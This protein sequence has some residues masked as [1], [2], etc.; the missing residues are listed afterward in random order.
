PVDDPRFIE[1]LKGDVLASEAVARALLEKGPLNAYAK[2]EQRIASRIACISSNGFRV[3]IEKTKH[4]VEEMR[5]RREAILREFEDKYGL[6]T[7]GDA[8]WATNEGNSAIL[9]AV[10]DHG[11]TPNIIDWPKA[12]ARENRPTKKKEA[13]EKANKLKENVRFWR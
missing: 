5:A 7:E 12:P 8:P 2:R 11:I 13:L 4:R 1:Y 10:A 3:D 9:A 6:P